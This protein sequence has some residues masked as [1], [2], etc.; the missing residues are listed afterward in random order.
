MLAKIAQLLGPI[1]LNWIYE[2]ISVFVAK[3]SRRK[4]VKEEAKES[5]KPLKDAKTAEEI[6]ASTRDTLNN[7]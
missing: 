6:D 2:K 1:F 7:L 5:V 3:M 4:E